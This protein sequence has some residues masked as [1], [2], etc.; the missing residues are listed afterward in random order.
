[1]GNHLPVSLSTE[2]IDGNGKLHAMEQSDIQISA[3]SALNVTT[4]VIM[5][6][7]WA[8]AVILIK[9]LSPLVD[10]SIPL[11]KL[12]LKGLLYIIMSI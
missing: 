2:K 8:V 3:C 12:H 1:M 4:I 11:F 7:S 5:N 6:L 9:N 10:V